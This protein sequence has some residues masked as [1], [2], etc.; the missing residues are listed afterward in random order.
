VSLAL[1]QMREA[2]AAMSGWEAAAVLLA[3]AYLLL[4]VRESL[5]CWGAAL[6]STLIYT[7]L[8]LRAG[9]YM[10]SA[11]QAFYVAMAVYG[12]YRWRYGGPQ[13]D[14][15]PVTTWPWRAHAVAVAGTL[16][17]TVT[18]GWLLARHTAAQLPYLDSFTT[19]AS[20]VTTW[21]VARKLLENWIYWFAIDSVSIYLY[22]SRSL[23]LTA[24]L[25]GA[26]LVI[27][28]FGFRRWRRSWL[29]GGATARGDVPL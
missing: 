13:P 27:I 22:V 19:W 1:V 2:L 8:F 4:A 6:V 18:S 25:F 14:A 7:A 9:L 5:W 16:A 29:A 24:A 28:V 3:I 23:F 20:I 26:Y 21:M 11:L 10:E 17:L 15:L 12:W